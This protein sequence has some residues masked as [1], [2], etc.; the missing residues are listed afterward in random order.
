MVKKILKYVGIVIACLV[1]VVLSSA[2]LYREYLQHKVVQ[3]RAITSLDG[4]NSLQA[5]RIG[6]IDQWIEVRGQNVNNPILLFIHGGPGVA[7]IPMSG[8]FQNPW[9]KYFTVVQWDQRGAGKTYASNDKELQRRTMNVPQMEQDTVD[10]VNYLRARFKREKI[11]V[12][13]HSWGSVLGLWLAH[14]HPELIYAYIGTGQVVNMQQN[15][16]VGYNDALQEARTR[17]NEQAVKDLESIAPYPPPNAETAKTEIAR[18]WE[19]DLLARSPDA[20]GFLDIKRIV[21]GI[22][23]TPGYSLADDL[24]FFRGQMLSLNIFLPEVM[25]IDLNQLGPDFRVPIFFFEGRYDPYC[26][27]SLVVDYT[28]TISAPQKEV[29]WF[30]GSGHFPFFEEQQKFK[31]E[32]VQRVL[33]L[34]N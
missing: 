7:F 32:L 28:K 24:G 27:P 31:D 5:V 1:V 15:E 16:V 30:D 4:I 22:V 19:R 20:A 14:E 2:L 9:E 18:N 34:A 13:G 25:K 29:V 21:T 10:V 3:E 12:L 23:S 26:R 6:G 17:H 33:P 8:A 11:F